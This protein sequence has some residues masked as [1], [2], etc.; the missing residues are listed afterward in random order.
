MG[1]G[2][3]ER[4]QCPLLTHT[5]TYRQ[6][7]TVRAVGGGH[8]LSN[9]DPKSYDWRQPRSKVISSN[10]TDETGAYYTKRSKSERK[11]PIQYINTYIW[12]L[13]RS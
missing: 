9:V 12:N 6:H 4:D 1:G 13:E 11:T 7:V 10:E 2:V 8:I 3:S 5:P